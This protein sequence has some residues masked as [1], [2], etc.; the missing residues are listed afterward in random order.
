MGEVVKAVA[1]LS[2]DGAPAKGAAVKD[3]E[4]KNKKPAEGAAE[5]AEQEQP[6]G[7]GAEGGEAQH[8]AALTEKPAADAEGLPAGEADA[9]KEAEKATG[10]DLKPY[11]EEYANTGKL[12]DESYSKLEKAGIPRETVDV[13]VEG[14]KAQVANRLADLSSVVGGV[15]NY[16]A[17]INWG[18]ANLSDAEKTAAV[19]AL[20]GK[21]VEGAKVFLEG[22]NAKF[23]KAV[24]KTPAKTSGGG[25]A[26]VTEDVFANR[27]EQAK[28]MRDP[29][30][31]NDPAY[32]AE[33]TAKSLRSFGT[34]SRR[35]SKPRSKVTRQSTRRRANRAKR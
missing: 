30:Y 8:P 6:A 35:R 28:A 11:Q 27:N 4:D 23:V 20:S 1:N 2:P 33:V 22:L 25:K 14:L 16:N 32:R 12:S 17:I 24:G 15:D 21:D 26:V 10:L 3:E 13:Y 9:I 7:E 34:Q 19:R 18:K 29:R 31:H 5:G